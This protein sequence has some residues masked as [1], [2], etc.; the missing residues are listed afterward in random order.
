MNF[1][2][3][4]NQCF[5]LLIFLSVNG[6]QKITRSASTKLIPENVLSSFVAIFSFVFYYFYFRGYAK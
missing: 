1:H 6:S 4:V 3:F 2:L 5:V